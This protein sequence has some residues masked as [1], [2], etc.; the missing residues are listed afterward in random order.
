MKHL[1]VVMVAVSVLF[2]GLATAVE[3]DIN[4]GFDGYDTGVRPAGWTFGNYVTGDQQLNR[5]DRGYTAAG[6]YGVAS[7]SLLFKVTGER[8]TTCEFDGSIT[9]LQFW[10]RSL[11]SNPSSSLLIEQL[12]GSWGTVTD[13][14]GIPDTAWSPTLALN[15]SSSQVR[16]TFTRVGTAQQFIVIDD[17]QIAGASVPTPT[18]APALAPT[19]VHLVVAWDDYNGD[20]YTDYALFQAGEWNIV[21][22]SDGTTPIT[23]GLIWGDASG[24]VPAPGDYDGDGTADIAVYNRI[25]SEWKVVGSEPVTWGSYGDIP[26]PD[27][28]D[29]DG[30][31]DFA[32]VVEVN[33]LLY[34][35]IQGAA[36]DWLHYGYAGDIPV[37]GDYDAD[38]TADKAVI[39]RVSGVLRWIYQPSTLGGSVAFSYGWDAA[40]D[41]ALPMDYNGDGATDAVVRRTRSGL[42]NYW[43]MRNIGK[44]KFGY[45]ADTPVGGDF[46]ADNESNIGVFVPGTGVWSIYNPY[47]VDFGTTYGVDGDIPVVG[48]TW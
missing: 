30:T 45:E 17:V 18:P 24:D 25:S 32:T 34:W 31:T 44:V 16:F 22:G 1:S 41:L 20:G 5:D 11:G 13:I 47:G 23:E 43:F 3:A 6:Y 27:D 15:T 14:I 8:A 26:V 28:Y 10:V 7:P 4:E 21:R 36:S 35:R 37:P 33:G 38:G 40:S 39:R 42:T 29:G 2:L 48:Q 12:T 46:D 9:N 19:P